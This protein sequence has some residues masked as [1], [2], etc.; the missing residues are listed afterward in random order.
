MTGGAGMPERLKPKQRVDRHEYYVGPCIALLLS[1]LGVLIAPN[2]SG[3]VSDLDEFTRQLFCGCMIVGSSLCLFGSSFGPPASKY[4]PFKY[5]FPNF[6]VR[7]AYLVGAGGNFALCIALS[8]FGVA[9]FDAGTL[10]GTATGLVTPVLS[11]SAFLLGRHLWKE[12]RR[13]DAIWNEVKDIILVERAEE[14]RR[15]RG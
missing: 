10:V 9:L 6:Q 8:F 4:W 2:S 7:H 5:W 3:A 15:G 11:L 12:H 14:K 1:G 13:L